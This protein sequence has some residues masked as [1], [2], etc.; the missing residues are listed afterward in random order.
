MPRWSLPLILLLVCALGASAC[1]GDAEE[2]GAASV[3]AKTFG[4]EKDIK[5]GRLDMAM[6]IKA[7]G[8]RPGSTPSG[9]RVS[10]PFETAEDGAIPRFDLSFSVAGPGG[11]TG[12]AVTAGAISTGTKGFLRFRDQ[13]Y[14]MNDALFEQM[15]Q[16][17]AAQAKQ[18]EKKSGGAQFQAL[19]VD[20]R[21]WLKDAE[22]AGEEQM[23]GA[24]TTHV[25][26]DIETAK[27]LEDLDKILNRPELAGAAGAAPTQLSAAQKKLIGESAKD[28]R[29]DLWTGTDDH[30]LRRFNLSLRF[31]VPADKEAEAGGL[32]DGTMKLDVALGGVNERQRIAAPKD[33][34]PL[35]DLLGELAA[36]VE[37]AQK[38][39]S[40]QPGRPQAPTPAPSPSPNPVPGAD[41][42][43][44]EC[45]QKAA[46]DV[47]KLQ[48]CSDLVG[49]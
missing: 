41:G 27:F 14:E 29:V 8:L 22:V 21:R 5:S 25:V 4:E 26:A 23:G 3:L 31:D 45:V 9:L 1:G 11:G 40:A 48:A 19:G 10:G 17:Y 36:A 34:K 33:A 49:A 20:P 44:V 24:K 28:A 37:Q 38:G 13:A 32:K 6:D 42:D 16:G 30:I 46:G 35:D 12:G 43:Y 18:N 2:S 47:Q 7:N 15:K 39:Q